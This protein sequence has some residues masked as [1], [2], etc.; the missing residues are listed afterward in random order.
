MRKRLRGYGQ[1]NKHI[2]LEPNSLISSFH[3]SPDILK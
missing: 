2:F 3:N 1:E